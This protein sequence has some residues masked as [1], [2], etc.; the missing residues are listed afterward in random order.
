MQMVGR[1][2]AA[3]DLLASNTQYVL[4]KFTLFIANFFAIWSHA[5]NIVAGLDPLTRNHGM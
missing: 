1:R 4:K 3:T 2:Q 5:A